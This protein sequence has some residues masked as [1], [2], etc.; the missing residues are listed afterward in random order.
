MAKQ[1]SSGRERYTVLPV[2][3]ALRVLD[4]VAGAEG[5][6][7]LSALALAVRL[8][9]TT[10]FRYL[11]SLE[12]AGYLACDPVAETW[13]LGAR[14]RALSEPP[15]AVTRLRALALPIMVELR[16]R[17]DETVNLGVLRGAKVV[18]VEIVQSNQ[19]LRLEA[20]V[21]GEDPAHSTALGR[22]ILAYLPPTE[23]AQVLTEEL[24]GRTKRTVR[25]REA[26]ETALGQTAVLGYA[27]ERGENEDGA[28]CV[29]AAILGQDGRP[30]GALSL[31]APESRMSDRRIAEAGLALRRAVRQAGDVLRSG[32]G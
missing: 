6:T 16:D 10:V 31:S 28:V 3:K 4:L 5:G 30:A 23:R 27:V 14:F 19:R 20:Q 26:V 13:S 15:D 7:R 9:K 11:C 1:L 18:Y 17:F 21:G 2:M 32:R 8:P 29:G 22:A 12:A 25:T 24:A